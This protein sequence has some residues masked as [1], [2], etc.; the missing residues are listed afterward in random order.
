M[1][2]DGLFVVDPVGKSGGLALFWKVVEELEIQNFSRRNINAIVRLKDDD[3]PWKF[4]CFYGNSDPGKRVESWALLNQL[5]IF[6]PIP[7]L[8]VGDFNEITCQNEKVGGNRRC[9]A[10]MEAFRTTLED[11]HLS[12]LGF[13]GPRFTWSNKH[14][15][16][17]LVQEIG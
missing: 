14:Q 7:W 13:S 4:T 3:S 1:G 10:Q 15:D 8:C 5:K 2:Y 16:G 6:A 12:D 11:C 9:E 17:S